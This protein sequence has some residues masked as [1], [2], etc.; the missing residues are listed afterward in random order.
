MN[1]VEKR[2]WKFVDKKGI[3]D[4]WPWVGGRKEN[5]RGNFWLNRKIIQAH[6]MMWVLIHGDIPE[7][8][9]VCH[10]CDNGWCVNPDHLFLG[11]Y[12]DNSKDMVFKHRHP[13]LMRRGENHHMA[14]LTDQDVMDIRHLYTPYGKYSQF[15]L[16]EMYG[17]ARTTIQ[18]IVERRTWKHI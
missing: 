17:V 15:K 13:W 18:Q 7:G 12:S 1:N 11:T 9:L 16:A 4:C 3:D 8:M 6:R 14:I 10:T 2:F 5:G